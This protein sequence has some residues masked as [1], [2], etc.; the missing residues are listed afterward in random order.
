MEGNI[1]NIIN[2]LIKNGQTILLA[3]AAGCYLIGAYQHMSGGKD[4]FQVAK[5]WYKNTTIGLF[6]GMSVI[7]IVSFFQSKINF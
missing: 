2:D 7:Q 4:G 3:V 5:S 6:V 1:V